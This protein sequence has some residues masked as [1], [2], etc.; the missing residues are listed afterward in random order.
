MRLPQIVKAM[1]D[2]HVHTTF[3]D[4]TSTPEDLLAEAQSTGLEALA[5]T[6]HDTFEGFSAAMSLTGRHGIELICGVEL[7]TRLFA[8]EFNGQNITVH[9]LG[10]FFHQMPP[11]DFR[12]WL[13]TIV[14]TRHERNCQLITHLQ[15]KNLDLKW[16]DLPFPPETVSR[17]HI[18]RVIVNKGYAPDRQSAF[19]LYLSDQAL[20]GIERKLPSVLEGIE[21]IRAA[22]GLP[23]LAHPGRLPFR[24]PSRLQSFIQQ[25]TAS[26]LQA[27]EVY[28]SDHTPAETEH[29]QALAR[30][31]HLLITGGSDYHGANTPEITLGRGRGNLCLEY[32]LI[33]M[34]K[35]SAQ[36]SRTLF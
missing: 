27:L 26:G 16:S 28:H 34:M 9:L 13:K 8:P 36:G 1:I 18:A 30:D 17:A 23:S 7:S 31:F 24:E 2:L 19:D 22:G 32:A 20:H 4:G 29:F 3:S 35:R 6:D 5:I 21:R 33:E 25:L 11:A 10:Y 15:A 14:S 12:A